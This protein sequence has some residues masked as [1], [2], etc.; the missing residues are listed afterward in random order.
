[1]ESPSGSDAK[2]SA[3]GSLLIIGNIVER[4]S[5]SPNADRLSTDVVMSDATEA[6][7]KVERLVDKVRAI[8]AI[9]GYE[10]YLSSCT[11]MLFRR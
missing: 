9:Y 6:F 7:P 2:P 4:E 11:K 1:M 3:V 8:L 5:R 10:K